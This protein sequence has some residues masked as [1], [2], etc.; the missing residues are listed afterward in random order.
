MKM[1]NKNWNENK[2]LEIL[3]ENASGRESRGRGG[4]C[5]CGMERTKSENKT[6]QA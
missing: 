5:V 6:L 1:E 3:G 2:S 4:M